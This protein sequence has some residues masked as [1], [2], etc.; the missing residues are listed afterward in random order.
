M[1]RIHPDT[2]ITV[3]NYLSHLS[4]H[5][6]TLPPSHID[7]LH[8]YLSTLLASAPALSANP[9]L[10]LPIPHL[11]TTSIP[12]SI[13]VGTGLSITRSICAAI[14]TAQHEVLFATCFWAPSASLTA[15]GDSLRKLSN[16]DRG[17]RVRIGFS[18]RSLLQKLTHT[19]SWRGHT[20]PPSSWAPTLGLPRP[21]ELKGIDLRVKSIFYTPFS[22]LHSKFVIVDRRLLLLPS[23]NVSWEVWLEQCTAFEGAVVAPF[24]EFWQHV[25]P[26]TASDLHPPPPPPPPTSAATTTA[27][28]AGAGRVL[29][30][31]F[32][33]HPHH[34]NPHWSPLSPLLTCLQPRRPAPIPP[35][36]PMTSFIL[37]LLAH[38]QRSVYLHT[39]NLTAEPVL[40]ALEAAVL[41]GVKVEVVTVRNMMRLET[42]VTGG[43]AAVT[44]LCVRRLVR[45]RGPGQVGVWYYT[46][47]A[48]GAA[49]G[50]GEG[51]RAEEAVKSHVKALIVDGEVTVLG[52]ANADRASW[53]TSQEVNVAVLDTG[54]AGEVRRELVR[55]LGGRLEWVG[56]GGGERGERLEEVEG[57]GEGV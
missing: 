28:P 1:R 7:L 41:R 33:P 10:P 9:D 12:R 3:R 43:G 48:S 37:H 36:T 47:A 8:S 49:G 24:V 46:G 15:L 11:L 52:S 17:V 25:W 22:V 6:L 35:V 40:A 44:E 56:L 5:S 20:Y 2:D 53:W 21:E 18:S 31:L 30:T 16:A 14:E 57:G 50:A 45:A 54:F 34:R 29:P 27:P 55:G 42:L 13:T 19:S 38:A 23:A 26:D 32:L 4:T 39:P 51:V